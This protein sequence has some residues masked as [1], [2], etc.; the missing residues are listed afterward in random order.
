LAALDLV[1][2]LPGQVLSVCSKP[3]VAKYQSRVDGMADF[4]N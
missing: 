2:T 3:I 4:R 1:L